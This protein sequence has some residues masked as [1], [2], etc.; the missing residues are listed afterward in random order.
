ME[1]LKYVACKKLPEKY[2][3]ILQ[4]AALYHEIAT[5]QNFKRTKETLDIT[6]LLDIAIPNTLKT[7]M[8]LLIQN[9]TTIYR[10]P[11]MHPRACV[12]FFESYKRDSTLLKLQ[13]LLAKSCTNNPKNTPQIEESKLLE[14]FKALNAYSPKN[15]IAQNQPSPDAIRKKVL[16]EKAKICEQIL[17]A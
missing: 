4:F 10:L 9:H 7:P 5:L 14:T 1:V 8:L 3:L 15:W 11:Q 2:H 6:P 13:I 12:A 16:H 17:H